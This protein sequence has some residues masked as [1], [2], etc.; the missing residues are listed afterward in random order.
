[1]SKTRAIRFSDKEDRLIEE[2]LA[3]NTF[4]DFSTL[5]RTAILAFMKEPNLVFRP[6][7]GEEGFPNKKRA[8]YEG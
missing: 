1:M 5:A 4:F 2:F 8:K 3:K 6:V 7:K